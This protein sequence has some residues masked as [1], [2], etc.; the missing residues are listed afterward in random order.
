MHL[1]N[2]N[3]LWLQQERHLEEIWIHKSGKQ[4]IQRD[5]IITNKLEAQFE[6]RLDE[7]GEG[8]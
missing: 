5:E 1:D 7:I 6:D 2:H 8:E 4:F 3:K